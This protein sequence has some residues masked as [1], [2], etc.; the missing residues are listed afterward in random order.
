MYLWSRSE[1]INCEKRSS[2]STARSSE[3]RI[4]LCLDGPSKG[5]AFFRCGSSENCNFFA[6]KDEYASQLLSIHSFV[7][8][9]WILG[10]CLIR[11]T[12]PLVN[13]KV[14]TIN[15]IQI[16]NG[17]I[18]IMMT[19]LNSV[20]VV[21]V[22]RQVRTEFDVFKKSSLMSMRLN[23]LGHTRRNCPSLNL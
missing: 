2:I 22:S 1:R 8:R 9:A 19:K 21:F 7:S 5:R 18:Q 12:V 23:C 16:A 14:A 6:W 13:V 10:Q 17:A 15:S 4:C 20:N 11:R 3:V